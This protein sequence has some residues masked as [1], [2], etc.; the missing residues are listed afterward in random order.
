MATYRLAMPFPIRYDGIIIG[1]RYIVGWST[2]KRGTKA[3]QAK[4]RAVVEELL[5]MLLKEAANKIRGLYRRNVDEFVLMESL[6]KICV[7]LDCGIDEIMEF[8]Q[9]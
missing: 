9:E 3:A 1:G 4:E 2:L 8:I 6:Y 5:S 7:T